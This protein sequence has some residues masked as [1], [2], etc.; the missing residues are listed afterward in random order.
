MLERDHQ[1]MKS[2]T[3]VEFRQLNS[4]FGAFVNESG[5]KKPVD[6]VQFRNMLG[7]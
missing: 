4:D 2:T 6:G 1:A 3:E 5:G 7:T